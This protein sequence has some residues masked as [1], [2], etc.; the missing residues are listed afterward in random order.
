MVNNVTIKD[1]F[2]VI[3]LFIIDLMLVLFW[4]VYTVVDLLNP[5]DWIGL[6]FHSMMLICAI[7]L[8]HSQWR[9]LKR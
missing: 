1:Q 5:V 2:Q 6:T 8:A 3:L 7:W 4:T 9:K